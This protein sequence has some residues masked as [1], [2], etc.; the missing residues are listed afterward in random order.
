GRQLL[1]LEDLRIVV[2]ALHEGVQMN[3]APA[4]GEGEL[5]LRREVLVAG[6]DDEI[7][8]QGGADLAQHLVVQL[9]RKIEA[10][11]LGAEGAGDRVDLDVAILAV[12]QFRHERSSSDVSMAAGPV[13]PDSVKTSLRGDRVAVNDRAEYGRTNGS[14]R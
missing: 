9:L 12:A 11:D 2:H 6:E 4:L 8:E 5:T 10:V 13:F 14:A 7:V 1:D 3:F